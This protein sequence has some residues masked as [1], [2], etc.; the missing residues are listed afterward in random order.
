M[1]VTV[2][3]DK[4]GVK[5]Q[6]TAISITY[7]THKIKIKSGVTSPKWVHIEDLTLDLSLMRS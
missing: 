1:E 2:V 6:G 7:N 3:L 5:Y 4:L